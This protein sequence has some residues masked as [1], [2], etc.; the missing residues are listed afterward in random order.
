MVERIAYLPV[1][2]VTDGLEDGLNGAYVKGEVRLSPAARGQV[3]SISNSMLVERREVEPIHQVERDRIKRQLVRELY[4]EGH[5]T[6]DST[7]D[8]LWPAIESMLIRGMESMAEARMSDRVRAAEEIINEQLQ[9]LAMR[10][11]RD[12]L[13]AFVDALLA[14]HGSVSRGGWVFCQQCFTSAPCE[15][16]RLAEEHKV[17]PTRGQS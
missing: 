13:Q 11:Q 12:S 14:L 3:W 1:R 6:P 4:A 7:I 17:A 16:R 5:P 15:T 2:V 8:I 10:D 9:T